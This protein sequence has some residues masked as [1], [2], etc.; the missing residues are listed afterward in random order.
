[1]IRVCAWCG[2]ELGEKE[3]LEDRGV[4]HGMCEPCIER[5]AGMGKDIRIQIL[6]S[7][8]VADS[9]AEK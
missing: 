9:V 4:T 2:A 8:N 5:E 6:E 1:M 7:I 3:P